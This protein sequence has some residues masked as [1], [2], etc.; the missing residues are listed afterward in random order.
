[1]SRLVRFVEGL[2]PFLKFD[3]IKKKIQSSYVIIISL[4]LLPS[5]ISLATII[6]Q[7]VRYDHII[8]NVSKTNQ[9]NQIVKQDINNEIWDI[10]AG[11]EKFSQGKQY[12]IILDINNRLEDIMRTTSVTQNRQMLEVAGR[13][14]KTLTRYVDRLGTQISGG[15][16][17]LENELILEEIRGVSALISDLLQD[18]IVQEIKSTALT[19]EKIKRTTWLLVLLQMLI[20]L[21]VMLYALFAQRSVAMSINMPIQKLEQMSQQI[22][23]GDLQVSV[24]SPHVRELNLLTE[25]LNIMAVRIRELIETNIQEQKNLQKSEMKALQAQITPHFLYNTLDTIIWLAESR[26]NEQVIDITRAFSNFFRTS[27]SRGRDWINVKEEF[28]HV[29]NY[30]TIQKIRYSDILDYSV[31]YDPEM[32]GRMMVKLLLQ[33][34]VENALYHGIKNKRGKGTLTVRGWIDGDRLC[35]SVEDNGIGMT[36]ERL[37]EI[38]AQLQG[39]S[40]KKGHNDIYGLFNVSKRLELYY[41]NQAELKIESTY[42]EGTR[43]EFRVPRGDIYA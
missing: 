17:V 26:R 13:A 12:A 27:L 16:P 39:Q 10:F 29:Q 43:V 30:L 36:E 7:T 2:L 18:F 23:G 25:N 21:L 33:P 34:L 1:M 24:E 31:E 8:T 6:L 15:S 41:N 20:I 42:K 38:K 3:S 32:I 28:S 9:L 14:V 37:V 4:M 11:K 19:N 22:A 40:G 5:V 35:F